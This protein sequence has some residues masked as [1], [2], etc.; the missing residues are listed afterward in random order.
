MEINLFYNQ[1]EVTTK[2][3]DLTTKLS[4]IVKNNTIE[5]SDE[6]T[7][8]FLEK[9]MKYASNNKISLIIIVNIIVILIIT[10]IVSI[11]LKKM[12]FNHLNGQLRSQTDSYF[13]L[14]ILDHYQNLDETSF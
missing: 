8:N 2:I 10:I 11:V 12:R 9:S 5:S 14:N 1:T 3:L 4:I 7:N 6:T 13:D